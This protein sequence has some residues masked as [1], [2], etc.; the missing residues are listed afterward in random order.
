[1]WDQI[2]FVSLI[3]SCMI[4]NVFLHCFV[5]GSFPRCQLGCHNELFQPYKLYLLIYTT[6]LLLSAYVI[7]GFFSNSFCLLFDHVFLLFM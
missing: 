5:L 4:S 1:M 6:V 3:E 7:L 2:L